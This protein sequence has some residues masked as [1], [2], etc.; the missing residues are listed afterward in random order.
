MVVA[1]GLLGAQGF[2]RIE[3]GGAAG[4]QDAGGQPDGD[5]DAF[6]EQHEAERRMD[7]Q[8]GQRDV[9]QLGQADAQKQ[10]EYTAERREGDRFAEEKREDGSPAGAEGDQQADFSSPLGDGNG[11]DGDDADAAD[12]QRD[13]AQRA[14]GHGQHVEDVGQR[15]HHFFLGDD[16]EVLAAVARHH[17]F[18]DGGG[19]DGRRHAFLGGQVD[20]VEAVAV[21][22]FE[23]A[24][25]RDEGRVVEVD[26]EKLPLGFED[27]DD[28]ELVGAD[29]QLGAERVLA[30]EQFVLELGAE[31]DQ[32][33]GALGIV[34]GQELAGAH[35]ALED[36]QHLRADAIDRGPA[37]AAVGADFGVAPDAGRHADDVR[38]AG[39]RPGVVERQR[40]G[41]ARQAGR[42]RAAGLGLAGVDADDV[43]AEL[44][45]LAE[46]KAVDALADRGEQDYRR[47]ADGD[48]E[49]GQEA[50]QAL[51]GDGAGGE[52]Q[53][54]GG[55]H[56]GGF[57]AS[58]RPAPGRAGRR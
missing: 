46:H 22:D 55:E 2:D 21:E 32:A 23:G 3:A 6:G 36:V 9:D 18:L 5:G 12:Q 53:G 14:D 51:G 44:A 38:Q 30:A 40:P 4:G 34:R 45:E 50:A 7:R 19:D 54:V 52:L 20:F 39:Q 47:D 13:A 48:A 17:P 11:H 10:T 1:A 58:S 8:G 43:G 28:A 31:D 37:Q 57:S 29:A 41:A 27:A 25:G 24:G 15:R 42:R 33:S 56:G 26:A 49:Q 35:L 16:G